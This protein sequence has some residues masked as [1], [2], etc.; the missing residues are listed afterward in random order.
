MITKEKLKFYQK[1]DG[2]LDGLSR[3]I[4][5][6]SAVASTEE[7]WKMI[8]HL[9]SGLWQIHKVPCADSY[10]EQVQKDFMENTSDEKTRELLLKITLK[11]K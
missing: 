11:Q 3:S 5:S 8:E 6:D 1:Y 7:D 10:R 4:D 2:D 9:R